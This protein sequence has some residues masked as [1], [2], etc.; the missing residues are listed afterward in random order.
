MKSVLILGGTK[1]FGKKL[2]ELLLKNGV[3]V[4]IA[5]RGK[6]RDG[7]GEQVSR[8]IID[9]QNRESQEEAFKDKKWDVVFDQ[10]CYSPQ[11]ALDSV[12]ALAG[13]VSRY[14]LTSTQAVYDSGLNWKEEDFN[15]QNFQF[16]YKARTE[17]QGLR[18]Y[19][20]AKRASEAV[21]FT[22]PNLEVV[23][24]RFPIV[25]SKDDYTERLKFHVDKVKQGKPIGIPD[26][27]SRFSFI[28][29]DEAANFLYEIAK[30]SY[31]GPINPGS[32]GSISL[33]EIIAKV[34]KVTGQ[35]AVVEKE[36]T[37]ENASPYAMPASFEINT[38]RV[39]GLGFT[40]VDLDTL[41]DE[42]ITYYATAN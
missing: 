26:L 22:Q 13:K 14:I 18:G 17:Y 38:D 10:T 32:K 11:E 33:K 19:Q 6:E 40:F 2:V 23:A 41:I 27:N 24:V 37:S 4:T 28:L 29:A 3:N 9:R 5:T 21:L 7:F 15:P 1:Y 39:R 8:L 36:L 42:L 25:V 30:S 34:E 31:V 12:S 20:E 16:E 35:E